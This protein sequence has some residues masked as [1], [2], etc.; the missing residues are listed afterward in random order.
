M[1][2]AQ[3]TVKLSPSAAREARSRAAQEGRQIEEYVADVLE[4]EFAVDLRAEEAELAKLSDA[5]V[6]AMADLRMSDADDRRLAKLLTKN[7]E[8]ALKT[9]DRRELDSLMQ[10]YTAGTL[11]KAKGWA[12]AVRRKLRKPPQS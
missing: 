3:I 10:I 11:Q 9:S 1:I 7:S 6:L 5:E 8:G 12:E 2:M 4:E